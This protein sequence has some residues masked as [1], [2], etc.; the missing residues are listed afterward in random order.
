M[1]V[2]NMEGKKGHSTWHISVI[3]A[4]VRIID[5]SSDGDTY[6]RHMLCTSDTFIHT[7]KFICL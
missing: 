7:N 1:K 5:T 2:A 6:T 3:M 4:A